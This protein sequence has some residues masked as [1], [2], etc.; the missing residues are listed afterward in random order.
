MH[1]EQ[2][3][4]EWDTILDGQLNEYSRKLCVCTDHVDPLG[5]ETGKSVILA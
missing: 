4:N 1:S 5:Y 3:S 2:K